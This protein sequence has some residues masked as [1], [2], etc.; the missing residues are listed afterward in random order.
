MNHGRTQLAPHNSQDSRVITI[1]RPQRPTTAAPTE[2]EPLVVSVLQRRWLLLVLCGLVSIGVGGLVAWKYEW[3]KAESSAR[4]RF[5]PL[6]PTLKGV[7]ETPNPKEFSEML[8][9]LEYMS[10]LAERRGLEMD[11]KVLRECITIQA[12]RFSSILDVQVK[13]NDGKSAIDLVNELTNIATEATTT[14]RKRT[15]AE[16]RKE[17]QLQL[18][19]SA[20]KASQLREKALQ[21]RQERDSESL[22][23]ESPQAELR[24]KLSRFEEQLDDLT[25]QRSAQAHQLS[26]LRSDAVALRQQIKQELLRGRRQQLEKRR[27]LY[28]EATPRY[29]EMLAV[30]KALAQFE[31]DFDQLDYVTWRNKLESLG[32][33]LIGRL[34]PGSLEIVANLERQLEFKDTK[35]E[36]LELELSPLD[37]QL[38]LLET[39][40][41]STEQK[42]AELSG[43]KDLTSAQLEEVTAQLDEANEARSELQDLI[44]KIQRG[45]ET[46]FQELVVVTP[47]SWQTTEASQGKSKLFVISLAGCLLALVM[48]IFAWEH[49]FPSA[50]PADLASRSLGIPRISRGTFLPSHVTRGPGNAY[51]VNSEAIRLLALRIQQ[52]VPGPGA[53]VL[54]S[55][56]N[57]DKSSVPM[58]SYLAECLARR[59]ERV[60]IV[61][62]CDRP[63]GARGNE[64]PMPLTPVPPKANGE[65]KAN[66]NGQAS[67]AVADPKASGEAG[68]LQVELSSSAGDGMLGLADYLRRRD[69]TPD[70]IICHTSIQGVDLIPNGTGSFPSEGL[71]TSCLTDLFDQCRKLYT[72][73]LVAGPSTQHPSDLQMMS[74]RSDAILFTIPPHG[75]ATGK[76]DDVVRDLL[77]LGA[78]VIGIVS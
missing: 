74:A 49:F 51:P 77:E 32:R 10:L 7:Y 37:S 61:D 20:Q 12:D 38:S 14:N 45:E 54:F 36:Q 31:K 30:E 9:S 70:K 65:A 19:N 71:A 72:L 43:T 57:H 63:Q 28:N 22:T 11:P 24:Q 4:L 62:A 17:V 44:A 21:L 52:S 15:L 60:L 3:P 48:P 73:I 75:R 5:V 69:L 39:R 18:E 47:A 50:D 13:W 53:M 8:T 6:P 55:G 59:E 2:P 25:L 42:L 40:R 56:L 66:A 34:D 67:T 41:R 26:T 33:E 46:E 78:P 16:Y 76:G 27:A 1:A 58:I 68:A 29:Q 64:P 23:A 35:I